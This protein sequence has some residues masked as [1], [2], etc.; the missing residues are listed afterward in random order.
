MFPAAGRTSRAPSRLHPLPAALPSVLR[1]RWQGDL[2][3][4]AALWR[5]LHHGTRSSSRLWSEAGLAEVRASRFLFSP[6]A[7]S[8]GEEGLLVDHRSEAALHGQATVVLLVRWRRLL[9][10]ASGEPAEHPDGHVR[11]GA[12]AELRVRLDSGP[13]HGV[14]GLAGLR[15]A[16]EAAEALLSLHGCGGPTQRQSRSHAG[17]NTGRCPLLLP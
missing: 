1:L 11:R 6:A 4:H 5:Q 13:A 8:L 16:Q 10:H 14:R 3:E 7:P 12:V 17:T 9:R 15:N 2:H